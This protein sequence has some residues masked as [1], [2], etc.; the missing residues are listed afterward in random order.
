MT[1]AR[2]FWLVLA[3]G[4]LAARAPAGDA[5]PAALGLSVRKDGVLI[6]DG[7]P[8]RAIGVNYF[9]AFCRHLKDPQ[10]TGFEAGFKALAEA[11][12]PFVRMMGCAFWPT[13]QKPYQENK[14]E[15]F[16][17]FDAVVK[18]AEQHGIG[19]IPSLF[20][21]VATV[22]DLVGEPVSEW[23]NPQSKTH[24]YMRAY[25]KDVVTRYKDSPAIWG[26]EFGNEFNLGA[27]LPN[28]AQ[29]R[30]Q[31]VPQLGT[32]K[33]RSEKDEWTYEIV[34]AAFAAFAAEVRRYDPHRV[35]STGDSFPR[36]CAWHNWKE[37]KWTKDTP[38]QFAEM[39]LGDNPDPVSI[40]SAHAYGDEA[41]RIRQAGA[42]TAKA[43]KPLFVGEFG[44]PG[45]Q[46]KSEKEF[47]ALLK[48]VEE[49]EVPLAALWVYDFGHQKDWCVT[50]ANERSYQLRAI[51]AANERIRAALSRRTEPK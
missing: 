11:K 50:A 47:Q 8:Y 45:P 42:I 13:E 10:D 31:V 32:A 43:G 35:I 12:I 30:P 24:E 15:F 19:L 18:A 29:H 48:A 26:W 41:G 20:W 16:R 17:R 2:A 23:G 49:T 46:E 36:D 3:L 5:V 34:R 38:E 14:E 22:P 7:R 4:L 28:A 25:V 27:N 44:A 39:L 51:S 33:S 40:V 6:K 1:A 9:N 37:K 21:N